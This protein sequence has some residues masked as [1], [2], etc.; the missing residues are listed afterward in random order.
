MRGPS[1]EPMSESDGSKVGDCSPAC[2]KVIE[3]ITNLEVEPDTGRS[4][5]SYID[6]DGYRHINIFVH[7]SQDASDEPPVDLGVI[8]A[9]DSNGQMG[10]RRYVNFEE[11][12]PYPQSINFI[13]VS[14]RGSWGGEGEGSRY[15]A[16]FPIMGPFIR[17][18]VYNQAPIGRIVSVWGY[19]VS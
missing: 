9:F 12:L 17:V 2:T 8:F 1:I 18:F 3:F 19:L 7:F 16:R 4:H 14:G 11:N 15:L 13:Q 6:I 10:S 5:T